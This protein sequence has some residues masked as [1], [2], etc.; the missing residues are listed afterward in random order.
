MASKRES[1]EQIKFVARVRSFYPDVL[2]FAV[3][4]GGKR[5]PME[6]TRLKEEGV[7]PGAS[8]LVILEARGGYFGLLVE[9]KRPDG[10][11]VSEEQ[12]DFM[13]SARDKG[14]KAVVC[15]GTEEAWR[16]FEKYM[17][18]ELT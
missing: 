9:M 13:Y 18:L 7:L 4:N 1:P 8:D 3:P 12:Q 5:S 6:A 11:S 2:I 15:H 10:G 17:R 16:A 14:Y